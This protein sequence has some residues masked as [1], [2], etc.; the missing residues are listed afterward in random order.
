MHVIMVEDET[1]VARH[2]ARCVESVLG[3]SL[4]RL[5]IFGDLRS[6][7]AH[8]QATVPDVLLLD[9]NLHGRDGFD[10]LKRA[11]SGSFDTI[12]VSANTDRALEAFEYG[13]VDFVPKPFTEARLSQAFERRLAKRD[14]G[15]AIRY[16]VVR[17]AGKLERIRIDEIRVIH[18]A[19]DYSRLYLAGGS[20]RLHE[21]SLRSEEHPSELQ[22][23]MRIS[24]AV[25]F[26]KTKH[27]ITADND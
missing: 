10:L 25:I 21:K 19:N 22:S 2:L 15:E 5:E 4:Q 20:R 7:E 14:E 26:L 16:L 23:L 18:G 13:V 17:H 24:Y 9:L 3:A 8:L 11:V 27:Q 12:V 1:M 6:A